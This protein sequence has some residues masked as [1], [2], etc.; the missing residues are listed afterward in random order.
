MKF[1][2]LETEFTFGKFSSKKI[3]DVI[4]EQP[5]YI[6]WC[7]IN[8]DHFYISDEVIEEIKGIKP[9]FSISDKAKQKLDEK[10]SSWEEEQD[11]YHNDDF[12]DY[13]DGDWGGLYGEEAETGYWNTH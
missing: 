7:S 12:D 3:K 13:D 6:D 5:S 8:L 1:Y 4:K 11:D 10:Y 9:D 2:D